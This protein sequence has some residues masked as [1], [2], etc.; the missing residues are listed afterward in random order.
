M[1][2]YNYIKRYS[3]F[4]F[5]F[6]SLIKSFYK[7]AYLEPKPDYSWYQEQSRK[8]TSSEIVLFEVFNSLYRL[9]LLVKRTDHLFLYFFLYCLLLRKKALPTKKYICVRFRPLHSSK[10]TPKIKCMLQRRSFLFVCRKIKY[11]IKVI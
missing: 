4:L 9:Q 6:Y 7:I 3:C 11:A 5:Y 1:Y 8:K 10:K 2:M